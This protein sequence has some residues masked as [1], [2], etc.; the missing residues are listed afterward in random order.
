MKVERNAVI[1]GQKIKVVRDMLRDLGLYDSF[2][3]SGVVEHLQKEWWRDHI[4]ELIEQGRIPRELRSAFRRDWRSRT[5]PD[6]TR[7]AK[8]LIK[9]LLKEGYIESHTKTDLYRC[10]MKGNA[11]RMTDLLPR[12]NRAKAEVLLKGV[13]ERVA[14]INTK[15]ELLHWVTEVRVFGSY[16]TGTD[17]LG[18]LDLAIKIK[19]HRIEGDSVKARVDVARATGKEFGAFIDM[20]DY[21][22]VEVRR[23]VKNRSPRISIH[24][25]AELD[26]HPEW[27]AKTVYTFTPP[28]SP[29]H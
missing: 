3:V 28:G 11:F 8:T 19:R 27:G 6:L 1:A 13:L 26:R 7:P 15:A 25:I 9:Q 17:D 21:C 22:E 29:E 23:R 16:L 14:D 24:E 18:D 4:D 5:M 12:M 2:S 20:L 10:T